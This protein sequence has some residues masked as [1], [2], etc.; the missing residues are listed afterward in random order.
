MPTVFGRTGHSE[1]CGGG[2]HTLSLCSIRVVATSGG[3][4]AREGERGAVQRGDR[5]ERASERTTEDEG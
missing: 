1:L 5:G 2:P 3:K 4:G